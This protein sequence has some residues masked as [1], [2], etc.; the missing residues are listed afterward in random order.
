MTRPIHPPTDHCQLL[1]GRLKADLPRAMKARQTA[2]VSTLRSLMAAIDNAEAVPITAAPAAVVGLARDVPR[3]VLSDSDIQA[4]LG[5]EADECRK[6]LD[7]YER[8]GQA[9]AAGA[10]RA[11]LDL[12]EAY[13]A[14]L[15]G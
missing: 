4:I 6:A 12:I 11:A 5:R 13:Q 15:Y 2:V 3:K 7:D 10:M 14:E 1:R 8:M 9:E